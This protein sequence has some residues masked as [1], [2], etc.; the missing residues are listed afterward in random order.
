MKYYDT[1]IWAYLENP[2]ARGL[3]LDALAK[4]NFNYQMQSYESVTQK[5]KLRF[6]ELDALTAANYSWEDVYITWLLYQKQQS[7]QL[8]NSQKHI[9]KN[10]QKYNILQDIEL[11]LL[12]ILSDMELRGIRVDRDFLKWLQGRLEHAIGELETE[13]YALA[14]EHFNIQSPKQVASILF[15]KLWLPSTKKTKTGYS[16]DSEV[17]ENLAKQSP[18]ADAILRHRHYSK[19]L[20]TYVIALLD[21]CDENDR[22]HTSFNQTITSTGRLSSSQPNLQNIPHGD[23]IAWEIRKAFVPYAPWDVLMAFDYSQ[24]EVRLLAYMS[25]DV[26]L[27]DAFTQQKDI[28]QVTAEFIFKTKNISSTQRKFAKAVN[29]WVI[30][31]ISPFWLSKMLD[32]SQKDAKNY[33]DA[34]YALYPQVAIYYNQIIEDAKKNGY[35]ETYF[36]RRR[37][38]PQIQDANKVIAKGAERE[39]INM[40]IQGTSADIIKL[41]MIEVDAFMKK[42]NLASSLLLQVHDELIFNVVP[43]EYDTISRE[44]PRIMENIIPESSVHFRVDMAYGKS[45]KDCK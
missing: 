31:G 43:A 21:S 38:I 10:T 33:I 27:I 24:I 6:D 8:D 4:R 39:A 42:N 32:I 15:E 37:Y 16:V 19:L 18:L 23:D 36:W 29:F 20:S 11:P 12:P 41:A 7:S 45:W 2:W 5:K 1:M 9:L 34:F 28:H 35:V 22:I 44:I 40:P 30:Y 14:W 25:G 3:W 26:Q 17:L 13:I